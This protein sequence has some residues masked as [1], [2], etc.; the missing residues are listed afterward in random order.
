MSQTLF[1][2]NLL[3]MFGV[4]WVEMTYLFLYI[5]QSNLRTNNFANG[6]QQQKVL[7]Y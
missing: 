3:G 7:Y 5:I 1:Q 6:R 4:V 2:E